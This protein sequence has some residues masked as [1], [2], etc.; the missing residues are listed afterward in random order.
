[1]PTVVVVG[2]ATT[3]VSS[4]TTGAASASTGAASTGASTAGVASGVFSLG[5]ALGFLSFLAKNLE[6]KPCFSAFFSS[7][8]Q[9][10]QADP[11]VSV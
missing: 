6:K 8:K 5:A 2:S 9:R 11:R 3:G 10:Q 1:M 7:W 4:A